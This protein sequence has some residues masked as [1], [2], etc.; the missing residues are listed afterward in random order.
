[1]TLSHA[2][3]LCEQIVR[4]R[5]RNFS[6]GIRLLPEP[7]RQA[8]SAVYALARRIDDIGDTEGPSEQRLTGLS[9]VRDALRRIGPG[10]TNLVLLALDDA[11]RRYPIPLPAFDE[12]IDGCAA[13]VR[14]TTY[15]SFDELLGYCRCVAGSVG[16]L[17]LGV[18]GADDHRK[19]EPL[20]DA[21]GVALQLTNILRDVREDRLSGRVYL[22]SKDLEHFSCALDLDARGRFTDPP[23]RLAALVRHEAARARDWY[24]EGA[25]LVRLLDR[26]SAAC[27]MAMAGIYRSLL[28]RIAA[29]PLRALAARSSLPTWRKTAIAVRAV[30]GPRR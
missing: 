2:Y 7:K 8:L 22:P 6:Y 12:L 18:F 30:A 17:S 19:A 1:M 24:E 14:G 4:T 10:E 28:D 26:R 23:D 3:R 20:A 29:D 16:R 5:A 25:R 11:A 15:Q 13:D 9:E 27:T 21:L